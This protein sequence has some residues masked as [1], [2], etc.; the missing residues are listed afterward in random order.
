MLKKPETASGT[1]SFISVS[2]D[3]KGLSQQVLVVLF[4][5][6]DVSQGRDLL[7]ELVLLALWLRFGDP[8]NQFLSRLPKGWRGSR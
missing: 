3:C 6:R 7:L 8:F 1:E 2:R 5:V 4:P